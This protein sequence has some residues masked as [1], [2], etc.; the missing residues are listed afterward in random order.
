MKVVHKTPNLYPQEVAESLGITAMPTF[1]FFKN[2]VKV[3]S[4]KGA[5]PHGL[6]EK[7]IKWNAEDGEG[8]DVGVKGQVKMAD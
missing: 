5:D 6:E 1:L 3:D 7:L 8:D 2:N 4:F